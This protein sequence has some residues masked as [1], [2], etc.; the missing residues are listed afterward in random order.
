MEYTGKTFFKASIEEKT[1]ED[2]GQVINA[3]GSLY[4]GIAAKRNWQAQVE[5]SAT[6]D[7]GTLSIKARVPGASE[8]LKE[9]EV[10]LTAGSQRI[11]FEGVFSDIKVSPDICARLSASPPWI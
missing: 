5:V 7:A 9:K 8:Y 1:Q 3:E 2:G 4:S 11:S 10:D 6:S